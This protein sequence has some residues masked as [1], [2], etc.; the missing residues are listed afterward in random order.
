MAVG[1]LIF[2][3]VTRERDTLASGGVQQYR[4]T[5]TNRDTINTVRVRI[6]VPMMKYETTRAFTSAGVGMAANTASGSGAISDLVVTLT[7]GGTS[8]VTY[9]INSTLTLPTGQTYGS[10]TMFPSVQVD[11]RPTGTGVTET[12]VNGKL[13]TSFIGDRTVSKFGVRANDKNSYPDEVQVATY[14]VGKSTSEV[15]AQAL[16]DEIDRGLLTPDAYETYRSLNMLGGRVK[17]VNITAAYSVAADDGFIINV[18]GANTVTLPAAAVADTGRR[19]IIKSTAGAVTFA[20]GAVSNGVTGVIA[21]KCVE[22]I[23]DGVT[24]QV[25]GTL[26]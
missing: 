11:Q 5:V 2:V 24:W 23:S 7:A 21:T 10:S 1:P 4:L 26:A 14:L 19:L 22:L 8:Y 18:S 25:T 15:R 12:A 13:L 3:E 9:T 6:A 17:V 20:G 16:V